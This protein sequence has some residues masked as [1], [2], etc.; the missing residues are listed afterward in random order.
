MSV[1]VCVCVANVQH[2]YNSMLFDECVKNLPIFTLSCRW[3]MFE[4]RKDEG[5][6]FL[7]HLNC[8]PKKSG[9]NTA[10]SPRLLSK[11]ADAFKLF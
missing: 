7:C 10:T 11:G 1:C 5:E 4:K 8:C 9:S 6:L 2:S 3:E